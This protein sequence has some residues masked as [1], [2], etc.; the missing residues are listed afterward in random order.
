MVCAFMPALC[1]KLSDAAIE[2]ALADPAITEIT[3]QGGPLMLRPHKSRA[4]ASWYLVSHK[5]GVTSRAKLASWPTLRAKV[6]IAM[7]QELIGKLALDDSPTLNHWL[8]CGE[9]LSWYC[10]RALNEKGLSAKRKADI[11]SKMQVQLI[12]LIGDMLITEVNTNTLDKAL[13]EPLQNK[14]ALSTTRQAL[15][16]V[17]VAFKQAHS[18][19]MLSENPLKGV[20]FGDFTTQPILPKVGRLKPH[21]MTKLVKQIAA[22]KPQQQTLAIMLL[23]CGTRIGETRQLRWDH[24]DFEK[25]R[26]IIPCHLIKTRNKNRKDFIVPITAWLMQWLKDHRHYQIKMGYNG[27]FI[28]SNPSARGAINE[29]QANDWIREVSHREWTAHE[30]RK[31]ARTCW[32]DLGIDYFVG[33]ALLNHKMSGLDEAYIQT[34]VATQKRAALERWHQ[35]LDRYFS[36]QDT[37]TITTPFD[38]DVCREALPQKA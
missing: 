17:K 1:I 26:L 36:L 15:A 20:V 13:Y 8:T 38:F 19:G 3:E 12:P 5:N 34:H 33:E 2:K 9:L 31:L 21:H 28:F 37:D 11:K 18:V 22:A 29:T 30:L 24:I 35:E 4:T 16:L 27:P 14:Y 10:D 25:S 32:A 23:G 7:K 6:V